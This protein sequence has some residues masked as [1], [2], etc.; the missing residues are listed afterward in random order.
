[1]PIVIISPESYYIILRM[2]IYDN[3][4]EKNIIITEQPTA[5]FLSSSR[6]DVAFR[7]L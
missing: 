4:S 3:D 6:A 2:E 1:M 5:A 7:I